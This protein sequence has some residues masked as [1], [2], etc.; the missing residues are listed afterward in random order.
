MI[1]I[2]DVLNLPS[3]INGKFMM[4]PNITCTANPNPKTEPDSF[5]DKIKKNN[6]DRGFRSTINRGLGICHKCGKCKTV[7]KV[8]DF[9]DSEVL[10]YDCCEEIGQATQ[11][12]NNAI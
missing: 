7:R 5:F 11:G 1:D 8:I 4:I 12:D 2:S 3:H 6:I 10:C 9:L